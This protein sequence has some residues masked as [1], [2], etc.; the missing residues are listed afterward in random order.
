MY[1]FTPKPDFTNHSRYHKFHI[2]KNEL[3][4]NKTHKV[5][6]PNLFLQKQLL[7]WHLRENVI[8]HLLH[9]QCECLENGAF[10]LIE[11][12]FPIFIQKKIGCIAQHLIS[13]VQIIEM[14]PHSVRIKGSQVIN[15]SSNIKKPPKLSCNIYLDV[16]NVYF[17]SS[18]CR[19]TLPFLVL[20]FPVNVTF[21]FGS[22]RNS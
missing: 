7:I 12:I 5:W 10:Q 1:S 21:K 8:Q 17:K 4:I 14:C 11:Y 9:N 2:K 19:Y 18:V 13:V 22:T 6:N 15:R 20:V 16:V 3:T